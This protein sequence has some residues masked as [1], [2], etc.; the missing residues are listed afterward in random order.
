MRLVIE[1]DI[2]HDPDDLFALCYLIA[3]GVEVRAILVAAGD[4]DQIAIARLIT[5]E[6]GLDIPIGAGWPNRV[7]LSSGS[8]HHQLLKRYGRNVVDNADAMGVDILSNM[9]LSDTQL[10][11]MGP[12][13]SVGSHLANGGATFT[14]ATM[15]GGYAP[16]SL[17]RPAR[18]VEKFE[19]KAYMPTFNLNGDREGAAAFLS[20]AMPRQMVGKN[21][22]HGVLF[23]R[24]RF[25]TF[26][27]PQSRA[28]ELFHEAATLYLATHESKKF[29]D[30]TAAVCHL[31]PEV[32][33]WFAGSTIRMK[34]GW[35]TVP[36]G[37]A[38]LVDL[39]HEAMWE[40][41][42]TFS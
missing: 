30:P 20:A 33:T 19:G 13:N 10:F 2:G 3:A 41:L 35:T 5:R 22:C 31:H 12:L 36:G 17:Y 4:P 18:L 1:T 11:V 26:P 32:G 38:V 27:A 16:Y 25:A 28:A 8:I 34:D 7:K 23:D 39:D 42:R 9:D 6:C 24:D 37:D 15:Q 21:V 29:H 14:R 40:R